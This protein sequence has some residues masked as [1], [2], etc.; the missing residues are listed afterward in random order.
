M[1][2]R[3][4]VGE[5][6]LILELAESLVIV[7]HKAFPGSAKERTRRTGEYAGQLAAYR[8]VLEAA[9]GKPVSAMFLHFPFRAEMVEVTVPRT[10][11]DAAVAPNR[12]GVQLTL[13]FR[14]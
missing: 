3:L 11:F 2:D 8:A 6:D 10:A 4:L 7:D 13:P 5:V 9:T 12:A 14:V 1:D